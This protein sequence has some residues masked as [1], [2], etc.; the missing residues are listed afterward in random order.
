M[1]CSS[2]GFSLQNHQQNLWVSQDFTS[3]PLYSQSWLVTFL[4][5]VV[6]QQYSWNHIWKNTPYFQI[7]R[8][9]FFLLPD[10]PCSTP[11]LVTNLSEKSMH[12]NLQVLICLR[13]CVCVYVFLFGEV[14]VY[15]T[16]IKAFWFKFNNMS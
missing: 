3:G 9:D 13:V 4:N 5:L 10:S 6:P 16:Y 11:N 2:F 12:I 7:T 14:I 8:G 1:F 15:G